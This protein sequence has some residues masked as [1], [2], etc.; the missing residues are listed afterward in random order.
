MTKNTSTPRNP[1]GSQSWLAWYTIT[2]TTAMAAHTVEPRQV[3]DSTDLVAHR[4][5]RV[6]LLDGRR[7]KLPFS[8]PVSSSGCGRGR[9]P[10]AR[11][12]SCSDLT[13]RNSS[14]PNVPGLAADARLLVAAERGRRG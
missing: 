11:R 10:P 13:S 12:Q 14:R 7:W 2:A 1:P 4:R 8:R 3:R 5:V 6:M 9:Q